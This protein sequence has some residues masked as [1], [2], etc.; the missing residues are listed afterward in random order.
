VWTRDIGK[1][2]AFE[3]AAPFGGFK[4]S[5]MGREPG[6]YGLQKDTGVKTVTV[7]LSREVAGAAL[8]VRDANWD[9]GRFAQIKGKTKDLHA[10][11]G[12]FAQTGPWIDRPLYRPSSPFRRILIS[13][14]LIF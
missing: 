1:A 3:A 9:F 6:E 12:R 10:F 7:K 5:G 4:Q 13:S 2:R 8:A 14:L 11:F